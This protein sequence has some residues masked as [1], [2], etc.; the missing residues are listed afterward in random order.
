MLEVLTHAAFWGRVL[1]IAGIGF[2]L[3]HW[4]RREA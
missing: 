3:R 2:V 4:A 1:S